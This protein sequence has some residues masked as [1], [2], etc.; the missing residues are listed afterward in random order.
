MPGRQSTGPPSAVIPKKKKLTAKRSLNAL[1]IA[2]QQHPARA[3]LRQNRLGVAEP[4]NDE[5]KRALDEGGSD[6]ENGPRPSKRQRADEQNQHGDEIEAG[7]DSEGN[8][9]VLGKV[10]SDNDSDLDSDEAMGES[11]EERFE[12]F[13]FR[14]SSS[15]GMKPKVQRE[16]KGT[17]SEEE[18]LQEIDLDEGTADSGGSDNES[19][20]LGGDAIDLA[21]VL[22]D[23]ANG[24]TGDDSESESDPER[25]GFSDTSEPED[26]TDPNKLAFL[27][28][29]VSNL[30]NSDQI[31][32]VERNSYSGALESTKPSEFGLK[33]SR[34]LT[35]ADLQATVT[36]PFLRKSLKLLASDTSKPFSKWG[37]I[38]KKLEVPLAKRQQDR[39]DRA[40]A[41]EKSKET[42]NRW[43]D[44][45][46]HNRRAQ[47]LS[48]PLKDP[49]AAVA[50]ASHRMVPITH[51]KPVT[52]L[53]GVIQDILQASGLAPTKGKGEVDNAYDFTDLP[54]NN[55]SLEEVQARRAELR[56][57]RDL[58]FR[59]EKRAKRI[60]KIKSKSYRKVHRKERERNAQ[61]EKDAMA[62]TGVGD[63]EEEQARNDRR[64]AEERM[65]QRHRESRWA[66]S[67]KDS[68]RAAWDEDARS[69][70]TEMARR[71]EE[72]RRRIEG[73][74]VKNSDD[75]SSESE[76]SN[77]DDDNVDDGDE[78]GS[79]RRL[80][81]QLQRADSDQT[82]GDPGSHSTLSS[83][84]FI[85]RASSLR[86]AQNDAEAENI[87]RELNN[88]DSQS[89]ED[90]TEA[91]GRRSYGPSNKSKS[92]REAPQ[93]EGRSEFEERPASEDENENKIRFPQPEEEELEII[94]DA[95]DSARI[96]KPSKPK[97]V[98]SISRVHGPKPSSASTDQSF[99]YAD[100][101]WLS[102]TTKSRGKAHKESPS[103]DAIIST[104]LPSSPQKPRSALKGS[105]AAAA[106]APSSQAVPTPKTVVLNED[107]SNP[108]SSSD[109]EAEGEEA[110]LQ[111]FVLRNRELVAKAFAGDAVVAEFAA[112]KASTTT[113]EADKVIDNTLPGWGTWVGPGLSARARSRNSNRFLTTQPGLAPEKRKD[114]KLDKVIINEKRVKKNAKYLASQL[115]H[116]FE[117]KAQYERSLRLPV[118]PE[119][120]TK[121]TF[122][123]MTKPRVMVK[124]G[125]IE[126]LKRPIV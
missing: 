76:S 83:M 15:T 117:T 56:R 121:E 20:G 59:E 77:E 22:N 23:N 5:R 36:D 118:G 30:N 82:N 109:Y 8:E 24:S 50:Q 53:E 52:E 75:P 10:H 98:L 119:W 124:Q 25:F 18:R 64:R 26:A 123:G 55:V 19:D 33:S 92:T 100:N 65:G 104:A 99:P 13:T 21:D 49:S 3:Q 57:A 51:S 110:T 101:P 125:V 9:W 105:R 43:I 6:T 2:E 60:K 85:Q 112:E 16:A 32:S 103:G 1:A 61:R 88:Q 106:T 122:Q 94:V 54:A 31:P 35:V 41:Y 73:R 89:E 96:S 63:S 7:S 126:A 47:H 40:A 70:V 102:T 48:F 116:P 44:T 46:K 38:S 58:L 12:G 29:M 62:A 37:G 84:A 17:G 81:D 27:G 14:G 42:L 72:L 86:R 78:G 115:P 11:D 74:T 108:A 69:G 87:C 28:D 68:G 79:D 120:Q 39:L 114:A 107:L 45:V 111:P 67:V 34:K 91:F 93:P 80:L 113:N 66:K 4:G 90:S 71:G 95:A 97:E